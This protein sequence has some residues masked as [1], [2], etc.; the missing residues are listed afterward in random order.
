MPASAQSEGSKPEQIKPDP[1]TGK[2]P[3]KVPKSLGISQEEWLKELNIPDETRKNCMHL[4]HPEYPAN[5]RLGM[6][7]GFDQ[8]DKF[9]R[10]PKVDAT[11]Q[12]SLL[13]LSKQ[14]EPSAPTSVL[15]DR[16]RN[17]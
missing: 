4:G 14:P 5:E 12:K 7:F 17:T 11:T 15:Q 16:D 8:S 10:I 1:V 13:W 2:Y 9:R 6:I 3:Y